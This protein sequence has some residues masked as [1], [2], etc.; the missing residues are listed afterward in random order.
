MNQIDRIRQ[1]LELLR[2][3]DKDLTLFGADTH[4][5]ELHPP[6]VTEKL[7]QFEQEHGVS[8]PEQYFQFL[9]ELGNGG[10]GPFY[11]LHPLETGHILFYD[12]SEHA[13]HTLYELNKPFPYTEPWNVMDELSE[14]YEQIDAAVE[15]GNVELEEMLCD[16]KHDLTGAPE[17]DHGRLEISDY[18][19]GIRITLVVNGAAKGEVWTDDRAN[20]GG[21]YPSIELG[22]EGKLGFFDWYEK[23]LDNG[24]EELKEKVS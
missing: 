4:K 23:W 11:G 21:I 20:D 18:G 6:L 10:A 2:E 1:K 5:Y 16:K 13:A 22:N 24:M 12:S 14:L 19:C 9:T 15:S 17:N 8:L 3:A 7:R